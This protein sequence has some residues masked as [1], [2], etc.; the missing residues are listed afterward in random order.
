MA[1]WTE[2]HVKTLDRFGD[3]I[4]TCIWDTLREGREDFAF[5]VEL[6]GDMEPCETKA[7]VLEK[8]THSDVPGRESR[9]SVL[10]SS[11][12]WEAIRR[13]RTGEINP[14]DGAK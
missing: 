6:Y 5:T 11:G 8:A 1:Q 10:N 2:Y 12:D 4:D 3:A 13:W 9:Y 14:A 7:V